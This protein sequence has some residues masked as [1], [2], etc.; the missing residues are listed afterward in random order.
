MLPIT[1]DAKYEELLAYSLSKY[2]GRNNEFAKKEGLI[3]LSLA[4]AIDLRAIVVRYL[5]LLGAS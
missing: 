3:V 4:Q 2:I 1:I 5:N